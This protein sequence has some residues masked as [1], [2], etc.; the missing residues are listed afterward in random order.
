MIPQADKPGTGE[1]RS[2]REMVAFA[3]AEVGFEW[4]GEGV[5]EP[6]IDTKK[7][8]GDRVHHNV[9]TTNLPVASTRKWFAFTVR[10]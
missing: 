6:D 5:E 4:R 3:F 8:Y 2:V 7:R 9:S 10:S 1:P